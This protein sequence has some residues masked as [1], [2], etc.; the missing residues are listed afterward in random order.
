MPTRGTTAI[1]PVL[2]TAGLKLP[3]EILADPFS[4]LP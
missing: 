2:K 4:T 1:M 3:A